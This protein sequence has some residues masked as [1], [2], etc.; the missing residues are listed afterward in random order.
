MFLIMQ[1]LVLCASN[2][3]HVSCHVDIVLIYHPLALEGAIALEEKKQYLRQN[4][5]MMQFK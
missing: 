5:I 2:I 1:Y 4:I 3:G